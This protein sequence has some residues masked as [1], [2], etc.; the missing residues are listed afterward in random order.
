MLATNRLPRQ[1]GHPFAWFVWDYSSLHPH[2]M[3]DHSPRDSPSTSSQVQKALFIRCRGP[4]YNPT[5]AHSYSMNFG[6]ASLSKPHRLVR[7]TYK[8]YTIGISVW[9]VEEFRLILILGGSGP[10]FCRTM[11]LLPIDLQQVP[12]TSSCG[13]TFIL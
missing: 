12:V 9:A 11:M 4:F 8:L 3:Y 2:V 13:G 7:F 5:I 10:R 6:A 1:P